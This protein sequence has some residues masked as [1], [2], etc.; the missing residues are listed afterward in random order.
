[1]ALDPQVAPAYVFRIRHKV[2]T[3]R[4]FDYFL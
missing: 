2:R 1:V 3:E 4:D